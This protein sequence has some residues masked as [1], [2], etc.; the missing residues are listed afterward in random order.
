[1]AFDFG[2]DGNMVDT[3]VWVRRN[4]PKVDEEREGKR[5]IEADMASTT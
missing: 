3:D 2:L 1:M 4:V 5:Y